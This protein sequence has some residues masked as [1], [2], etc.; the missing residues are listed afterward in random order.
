MALAECSFRPE[1][2]IGPAGT[3]RLPADLPPHILLFSESPSRM[4]VTTRQDARL[5][6]AARRAGVPWARLGTVG[7]DR[8]RLDRD[9]RT[10]LDLPVARLNEAWRS[11]EAALS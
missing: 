9:G 11:L 2:E 1:G 10:L 8:L 4:V 6:E 3:F 7:R 5:E